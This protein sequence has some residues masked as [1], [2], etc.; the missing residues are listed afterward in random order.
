MHGPDLIMVSEWMDN[1]NIK[2]Y[3]QINPRANKPSLVNILS[4]F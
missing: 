3:L 4:R 2:Q 1:G